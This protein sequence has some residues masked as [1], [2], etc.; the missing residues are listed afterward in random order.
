MNIAFCIGNGPSREQ[1]DLTLLS[2][3]G[4]TYGCNQLI[5]D[6]PLDNTIV[7]DRPL[8]IDFIAKGINQRTNIYTRRR[9]HTYVQADNLHFLN[10]PVSKP[11]NEFEKELNWG[12][13][14]HSLNLAAGTGADIVVMLGYDLWSGNIYTNTNVDPSFWIHQIKKCFELHP[15]VQFVQIQKDGWECPNDWTADNFLMDNFDGLKLLLE[16]NG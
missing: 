1:F 9:W 11:H 13:G 16:E 3:V 6:F 12:S 4:P 15:F 5:E 8:L 14:T 10:D 2:D 7:V